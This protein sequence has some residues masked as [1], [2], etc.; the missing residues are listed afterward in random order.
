MSSSGRR[1]DLH[2]NGKIL[3]RN[4]HLGGAPDERHE[5]RP[6][7]GVTRYNSHRLGVRASD[8][9]LSLVQQ[10]V[11]FRVQRLGLVLPV[12]RE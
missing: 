3:A 6:D 7:I 9:G 10:L 1:R 2:L 12:V 5:R 8:G 11:K 4:R